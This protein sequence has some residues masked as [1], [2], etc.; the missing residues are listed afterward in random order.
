[1]KPHEDFRPALVR[2]FRLGL[3]V[4]LVAGVLCL[5]AAWLAPRQFYPAYLAAYWFWLSVSL[6]C[7][8]IS[9]IHHLT[10]GGWGVPIRR[11]LESASSTVVVMAVLFLP[12][13]LGMRTLFVWV[14]P[15]V[16]AHDEILQKKLWYLNLGFFQVRA[17]VYFALWI[18][19]ALVA[20]ALTSTPNV[21][22]QQRRSQSLKLV[23]GPGLVLL[24]LSLT[25]ASVDW[26]MSLEPHWFSS[27]WGVIFTGGAGVAGLSVTILVSAWLLRFP[28]SVRVKRRR[29]TSNA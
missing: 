12:I 17:L 11:I 24:G 3:L 13:L 7:L 6:G 23:S 8:A 1:M 10:G 22:E 26:A 21:D 4:G 28:P 16:I 29:P 18:V 25:F 19:T 27:M 9:M 20:N 2:V 15:E 14:D 5:L